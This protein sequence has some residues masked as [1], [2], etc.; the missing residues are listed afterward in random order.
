MNRR[1]DL[2]AFG[3]SVCA[4]GGLPGWAR[5][6]IDSERNSGPPSHRGAGDG[7][8]RHIGVA[9]HGACPANAVVCTLS[10]TQ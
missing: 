2:Y 6:R 8:D 7:S 4:A 10:N 9:S 3:R 5:Q 1:R